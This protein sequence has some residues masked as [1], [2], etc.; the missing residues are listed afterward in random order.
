MDSPWP[1]KVGASI[2]RTCGEEPSVGVFCLTGMP[3]SA[4]VGAKCMAERA[5]PFHLL[6]MHV[7]G[8]SASGVRNQADYDD[9]LDKVRTYVEG[10]YV[11]LRGALARHPITS[12]EIAR[13]K[14]WQENHW[15][16]RSPSAP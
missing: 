15:R 11:T 6:R 16:N 12:E 7:A 4:A 5:E 3:V 13:Q 14:S 8:C 10:E 9:W 2:C 1:K